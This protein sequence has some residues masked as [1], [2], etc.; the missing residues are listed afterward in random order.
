MYN[1][2]LL[3][4]KLPTY[5]VKEKVSLLIS[6]MKTKFELSYFKKIELKHII[7]SLILDLS[8]EAY[9]KHK[10]NHILA[11]AIYNVH[12]YIYSYEKEKF[13][14]E[15]VSYLIIISVFEQQIKFNYFF[16]AKDVDH[17]ECSH[18]AYRLISS[19]CLFHNLK[20]DLFY[21]LTP[22]K[23]INYLFF[24]K[25]EKVNLNHIYSYFQIKSTP[26]PKRIPYNFFV[27]DYRLSMMKPIELNIISELGWRFGLFDNHGKSFFHT[28]K[29]KAI[30]LDI[31][32]DNEGFYPNYHN[33]YARELINLMKFDTMD[34]TI[35][36]LI[37]ENI[38][39]AKNFNFDK[40]QNAKNFY[41]QFHRH[42]NMISRIFM[43]KDFKIIKYFISHYLDD[44]V[45]SSKQNIE[46]L[47]Y[48]FF[49][50]GPYAYSYINECFMTLFDAG[51]QITDFTLYSFLL[52][53]S[54]PEQLTLI[55]ILN[56]NNQLSQFK[57]KRNNNALMQ[58][59][60]LNFNFKAKEGLTRYLL[61][62]NFPM[63]SNF[64]GQ[65][66]IHAIARKKEMFSFSEECEL[67]DLMIEK[68]E[69]ISATTYQGNNL[70]LLSCRVKK[71]PLFLLYLID[72]GINIFQKNKFGING[73]ESFK[74]YFHS[75]SN[76][77][78]KDQQDEWDKLDSIVEKLYL[79]HI[80]LE[81]FQ[82][83]EIDVKKVTKI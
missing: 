43:Y 64:S 9:F 42:H 12:N 1:L 19:I 51:C 28:L 5:S 17:R 77:N 45:Q 72:K 60:T 49:N 52:Q 32:L 55:P 31:D 33:L 41:F 59:M 56:E 7:D 58:S 22:E 54:H 83:E 23:L 18:L 75:L 69:D 13:N 50:E 30:L 76:E 73:Y 29:E 46:L 66:P 25:S 35:D 11:Q 48:L 10:I 26:L 27:N 44:I 53:F 57:D 21:A 24:L 80:T 3:S 65:R 40:K 62:H 47:G 67:I 14:H 6:L 70:F 81:S 20:N 2:K 79:E 16:M 37:K 68:G 74:K 8:K 78:Y 38:F 63:I 4:K 15:Y 39:Y 36:F 34:S 61:Q 71:E 82:D